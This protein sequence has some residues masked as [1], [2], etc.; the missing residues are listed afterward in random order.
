MAKE[1]SGARTEK[2]TPKRRREARKEGQIA[3][4][5]D[6]V[7]WIA[8]LV[9][10]FVLPSSTSALLGALTTSTR[11]LV[12]TSAQG[13]PGPAFGHLGD[14]LGLMAIGL[15]P[16]FGILFLVTAGGLMAQGGVVLATKGLKPKWERVS[17]KAG[18]KRLFS[19]QSLAETAKALLRLLVF[20]IV[21]WV[22]VLGTVRELVRGTPMDLRATV[23]ILGE[24][25]ILALR[26][27]AVAGVLIGVA[28][29]LFQRHQTEKRLK[30][31]RHEVRQ[32][33]KSAEGDPLI[34]SR[35]RS[36]HAKLTRNGLLAAVDDASV[37]VVNPTHV[38]VAL[39]YQHGEGAPRVVAKGG[40]EI[41]RRIRE[42]ALETGIPVLEVRPL[43]RVLHDTVKVGEHVPTELFEAVAIVL[44][45]VMRDR[46]RTWR[47]TIR[48]L[49][50]PVP[51]PVG[52]RS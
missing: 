33:M 39:R 10:T 51:R 41:A 28:D 17:P 23:P 5:V 14:V 1:D 45:F 9:A 49:D 38:A 32:E 47:G 48:R 13:E 44:A 20:G 12:A 29:Y 15:A 34:R 40:D 6:L 27:S 3:R 8:L 30:M 42:R 37:V 43:A 26:V 35:R 22:V 24:A 7:Q 21:I 2:P 36:A 46:R 16:L 50:V 31:S 4:S 52:S 11:Q 19:A 18:F 25:L